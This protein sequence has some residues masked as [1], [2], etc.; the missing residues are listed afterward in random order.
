MKKGLN[1]NKVVA[2]VALDIDGAN[3]FA[4]KVTGPDV[5]ETTFQSTAF[6]C[7]PFL[8]VEWWDYFYNV[9]FH[10]DLLVGTRSHRGR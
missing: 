1:H 2:A 10:A 8:V 9:S 3:E 6:T 5:V 7:C 4:F